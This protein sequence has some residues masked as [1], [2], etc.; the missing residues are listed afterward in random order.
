MTRKE[1]SMF[2]ESKVVSNILRSSGQVYSLIRVSYEQ[3]KGLVE[4]TM[5]NWVEY[6]RTDF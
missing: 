6:Y 3:R 4:V 5:K 1:G 2:N